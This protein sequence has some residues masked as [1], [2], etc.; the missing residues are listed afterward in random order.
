MNL[1]RTHIYFSV[2]LS[3]LKKKERSSTEGDEGW[4][5]DYGDDP[6][7]KTTRELHSPLTWGVCRPD[8][9]NKICEGD[10]V[11]FFS[12]SESK[13]TQNY[14]YRLCCI[15]TVSKKVKQTDIFEVDSLWQFKE[16]PNLLVRPLPSSKGWE[17]YEPPQKGPKGHRDWLWRIA[18]RSD[19]KNNDFR[20][21][22]D[23]NEFCHGT[24]IRGST[25]KIAPNYVI[26]SSSRSKTLILENPPIVA[27]FYRGQFQLHECWKRDKLSRNIKKLTLDKARDAMNH[28][29]WLR[30]G[31]PKHP[32]PHPPISFSLSTKEAE[33]WRRKL[34]QLLARQ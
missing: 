17:H 31:T 7:F 28:M 33:L 30:I 22:E 9:R 21:I 4:P 10:I 34:I 20:E 3:R 2:F 29:R 16:Y 5:Y 13:K 8:V 19:L 26:F 25:I 15:S 23:K 18:E 12:C 1:T 6:S 24:R 11:V 32:H 14:T 27:H